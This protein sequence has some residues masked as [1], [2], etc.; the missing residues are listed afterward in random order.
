MNTNF[1]VVKEDLIRLGKECLPLI[2][3]RNGELI[4]SSH[5]SLKKGDIYL[6]GLNPGGVGFITIKDHLDLLLEKTTNSYLDESWKNGISEWRKGQ[7]PLQ[8]RVDYLIT[9]LGYETKEVCASN[10]IFV[11]SKSANEINY[12]LAGYCWRFHENILDIIK[13]K[14]ILCFG[15]SDISSYSFLLSLYQGM[16]Q[17]FPSGHGG[18]KC[19]AFITQI[20]GRE[21]T[22]IGIP[23][24]SYYNIIGKEDVIQ[25]IKGFITA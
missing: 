22:I 20:K 2:L 9:S 25:W 3:E 7:A 16:E 19:K 17:E 4:Y 11:T 10:L 24:L 6:L 13:P 14:I 15:I 1:I 21:T 18:W 5:E 8:K 23:H 12:G